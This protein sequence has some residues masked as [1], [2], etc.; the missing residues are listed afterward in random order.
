MTRS[1]LPVCKTR[2]VRP[3]A[4]TCVHCQ[5]TLLLFMGPQF[6]R[7]A[8]PWVTL[9]HTLGH[10]QVVSHALGASLLTRKVPG[11]GLPPEKLVQFLGA[12]R[13]PKIGPRGAA[14]SPPAQ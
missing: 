3:G 13:A 2:S 5:W 9:G 14:L 4:P 1:P 11:H 7:P 10:A 6:V 12:P 8:P